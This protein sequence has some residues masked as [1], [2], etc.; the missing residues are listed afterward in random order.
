LLIKQFQKVGTI[1]F[2]KIHS[3]CEFFVW[4]ITPLNAAAL[5]INQC[6]VFL[7]NCMKMWR[8]V[9]TIINPKDNSFDSADFWHWF[10]L[11]NCGKI[12]F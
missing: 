1:F 12:A 3:H 6:L 5:N 7:I 10:F 9:V 8:W 11:Q 2:Q 4:Q